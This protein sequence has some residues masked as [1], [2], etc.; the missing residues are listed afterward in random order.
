MKLARRVMAVIAVFAAML[1]GVGMAPGAAAAAVPHEPVSLQC[2]LEPGVYI[3][4]TAEEVIVGILIVYDDCK[5][6]VVPKA[7]TNGEL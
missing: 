7:Q 6:E 1:L 2:I 5:V 4:M 3:I